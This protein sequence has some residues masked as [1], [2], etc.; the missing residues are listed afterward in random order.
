MNELPITIGTKKI[1]LSI[2]VGI[3]VIIIAILTSITFQFTLMASVVMSWLLTTA[4]ALFA[5]F[6]INPVIKINP[7]QNLEKPVIQEVIKY[8]DRPVIKEI[9]IPIEN[10][11]IEVVEKIVIKEVPV[12]VEKIVY[13][14]IEKAHRALNI[15]R[16]EFL[17]S[18]QT[19]TYHKR[20][21]KFSKMLKRKYKLQSNS[22][23]FFKRKHFKACKTCLKNKK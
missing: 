16:Y 15:P 23:S 5:F 4:Y 11:T 3:M 10:K 12:E 18:T 17:G 14:T 21:C 20:T 2:I 1:I 6:L 19:K 8:V 9:Q 22:K 13:R 7:I